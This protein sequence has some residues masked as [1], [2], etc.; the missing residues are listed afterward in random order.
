MVPANP[1]PDENIL[2]AVASCGHGD[3]DRERLYVFPV[4]F[5]FFKLLP[6][7]EKGRS[8]LLTNTFMFFGC[9]NTGV[10]C[11][12]LLQGIFPILGSN[13]GLL[14]CREILYCMS[15]QRSQKIF[16]V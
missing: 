15:H 9:N 7:L 4:L 3:R 12:F 5:F 14:H 8:L 13:S 6:I 11:H 16:L 2:P 10:I 1:I